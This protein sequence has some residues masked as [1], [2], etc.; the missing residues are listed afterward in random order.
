MNLVQDD[1]GH[2]SQGSAVGVD[3]VAENL[4]GHDHD[5]RFTVDHVVSGEETHRSRS[6]LLDEVPVLLI[7]EGFDRCGVEGAPAPP[8]SEMHR[9]LGD[10][11]LA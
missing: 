6:V 9:R 2:I 8:Q 1:D 3:H 11:R 10:H 5:R 7:G 4:G